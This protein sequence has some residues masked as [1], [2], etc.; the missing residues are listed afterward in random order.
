MIEYSKDKITWP[1][2]S[3]LPYVQ[4]FPKAAESLRVV[5]GEIIHARDKNG[6]FSLSARYEGKP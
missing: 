2:A 3:P 1:H 4:G 5:K 6:V